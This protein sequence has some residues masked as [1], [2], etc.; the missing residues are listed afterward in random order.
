MNPEI[1]E[2]SLAEKAKQIR[3]Q[4]PE[5]GLFADKE[6][7]ISPEP[8][9][10][11][12][13]LH[14]EFEKLG[15]RLRRFCRVS[16]RLY[17]LSF[18]GKQPGWIAERLDA[19][20]PPEL[21]RLARD[22]RLENDL[23]GVIR[24]DILLTE[25]GW[26]ITELDSVPGGI[27][28]TGWLQKAYGHSTSMARAFAETFSPAVGATAVVVSEEAAVYR[29]EME[30]LV[31]QIKAGG[32]KTPWF[33]AAPDDLEFKNDA[34]F[35]NGVQLALIYRFFE[36]FDLPN[37]KHSSRLLDAALRG[38]I[39]IT[40][41]PKPVLEEK[42][43]LALFW[44]ESLEGFWKRELGEEDF[45][46][47]RKVIPQSWIVEPDARDWITLKNASQKKRRFVLK[48]SGFSELAWGGRS[49][50]IGHDLST[51]HWAEA[52]DHALASFPKA[53]YVMQPF[54]KG[55]RVPIDWFDFEKNELVPMEGRVRLCP[56]YFG[57]TDARN[58]RDGV[59]LA[60]IL[61]TICPPDKKVIHGMRDAVMTLAVKR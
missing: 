52:I 6:W 11:D 45:V 18:E 43:L 61:A 50:R 20:K 60:G 34:V 2:P 54:E 19:G 35:L 28:L 32:S 51:E 17:R 36:L 30:W 59:K 48:L 5:H 25:G 26:K 27:G 12:A 57:T 53:P 29:P 10:I 44:N 15:P 47:L 16:D 24:P 49:L 3:A 40:A 14:E 21:V 1:L 33:V 22:P 41:P 4:I 46:E 23:P 9:A 31:N 37:L 8:F 58:D 55:R 13:R 38:R 42:M 56:Y 39:L 7:R